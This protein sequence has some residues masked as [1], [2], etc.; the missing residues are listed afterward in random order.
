VVVWR[1]FFLSEQQYSQDFLDYFCPIIAA[2]LLAL[3][4]QV[5]DH[6][7]DSKFTLRERKEIHDGPTKIIAEFSS[8]PPR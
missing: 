3:F 2:E 8:P 5:I 7:Y 6:A 4:Y 1:A